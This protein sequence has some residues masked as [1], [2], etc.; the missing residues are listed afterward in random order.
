LVAA[1]AGHA[2]L[3]LRIYLASALE[4]RLPDRIEGGVRAGL[5]G[6]Q[7]RVCQPAQ[8]RDSSRMAS[9][10]RATGRAAVEGLPVQVRP[11]R[12]DFAAGNPAG[13][14]AAVGADWR[15]HQ[16][17]TTLWSREAQYTAMQAFTSAIA[18]WAPSKSL[19]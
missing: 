4:S 7:F 10:V 18:E 13:T 11:V 2:F 3:V 17:T 15:L 12:V 1:A 9:D 16:R 5:P 19:P 6:A 8:R 14:L